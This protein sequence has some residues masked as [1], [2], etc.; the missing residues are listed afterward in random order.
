MCVSL[1]KVSADEQQGGMLCSD[2]FV[3]QQTLERS[4]SHLVTGSW[5]RAPR[6]DGSY[7][8]GKSAPE[9]LDSAG[10]GRHKGLAKPPFRR[11]VLRAWGGD[12][13]QTPRAF[14]FFS[15]SD[16]SL[17]W[18]LAGMAENHR[19]VLVVDYDPSWPDM[20]EALRRPELVQL[21]V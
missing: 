8:A 4:H 11:C 20:F 5:G 9:T 7:R 18:S 10:A 13:N 14:V 1:N 16:L 15:H 12:A 3:E 17:A 19:R 6:N 2:S 21:L